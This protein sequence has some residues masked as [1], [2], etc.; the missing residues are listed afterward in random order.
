MI[1]DREAIESVL[2]IG[3]KILLDHPE[4]YTMSLDD[5]LV[6]LDDGTR[7]M[8]HNRW[9]VTA[10]L[11]VKSLECF[12]VKNLVI[13]LSEI[14]SGILTYKYAG[15][16]LLVKYHINL[17]ELLL[18]ADQCGK[19]DKIILYVN[20]NIVFQTELSEQY[21]GRI[22]NMIGNH[23]DHNLYRSFLVN[24][25]KHMIN[26]G[27][28]R[29]AEESLGN[30]AGQAQYD[31]MSVL[32]WEWVQKDV[33]EAANV[34]GRMIQRGSLWSKKA[35]I[36]FVES[37]FCY[38]KAI[39]GRYFVQLEN[40]ASENAELW[41]MIIRVFVNYAAKV[42][43]D[44]SVEAEQLYRKVIEYLNKIPEG[45]LQE[46][47]CFI[48]ALQLNKKI[49]KEIASIFQTLI[50]KSFGK[51][52]NVLHI[53][54][55][56]LYIQ[57]EN[58][59]W[60]VILQDVRQIFIA[61]KYGVNYEQFFDGMS[62]V[63]HEFSNYPEEVTREALKDMLSADVDIF[64]FGL[65]LLL[66]AGNLSKLYS[67]NQM[68]EV[69]IMFTHW[70][71]IRLLKGTLYFA[72][73]TKKICHMAFQLLGFS[74]ENNSNYIE[75]CMEEV[76]GNYPATFF[77][78]AEV[79]KD[80]KESKQVELANRVIKEHKRIVKE[81]ELCY[82]MKDLQPS[83]IHQNIYQRAQ[84][85]QYRQMSKRAHNESFFAKMFPAQV[86]KYGKRTGLLITGRQDEKSFEVSPF[87]EFEYSIEIPAVYT[88]D[89]VEFELRRR[90][91]LEEVEHSA[92][93][94]KGLPASTER[95]G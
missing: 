7:Q 45:T 62:T 13:Q 82:K 52:Q 68:S 61:N 79:Y 76:Y 31:F 85:D 58:D 84:M 3:E 86:L 40:M 60:R 19:F 66:E 53:L 55:D 37:G 33:S 35:A 29:L 41:Q 12:D 90:K 10:W 34:V 23:M 63:I 20:E 47:S 67:E 17:E 9:G 64:F 32:R 16:L 74:D 6:K 92:V 49:P 18:E 48:A 1:T 30:L 15:Y 93:S 2:Q 59:G 54:E 28:Q 88:K 22:V 87:A 81:R 70:Q 95:K 25:A 83:R 42:T 46:K 69:K 43:P 80:A 71:M 57:L 26:M 14:D 39:F 50:S 75:F 94:N 8:R 36:D 27:A 73:E 24:Y 56:Y 77:E 51:D 5:V 78:I 44:D 21:I 11:V 91:Y 38:D 65:G 89:P 4:L 72:V